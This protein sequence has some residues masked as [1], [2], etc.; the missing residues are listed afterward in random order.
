MLHEDA[1]WWQAPWW[2]APRGPISSQGGKH[3]VV[4]SFRL[5]EVVSTM[6]LLFILV[7][8]AYSRRP[9]GWL[10]TI[11]TRGDRKM[12][13]TVQCTQHEETM[14]FAVDLPGHCGCT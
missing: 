10:A 5:S 2:Q 12:L 8:I 4:S 13:Q 6:E 9:A 3:R 11:A 7:Y 14:L 1:Y